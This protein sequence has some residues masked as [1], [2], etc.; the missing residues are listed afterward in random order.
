[1]EQ[2]KRLNH[3]RG[4][5]AQANIRPRN[6]HPDA[7]PPARELIC[8]LLIRVKIP[9]NQKL[10]KINHVQACS[11]RPSAFSAASRKPSPCVG[12]AWIVPAMSSSRA[13]ISMASE[14]AA[15]SSA[16][17]EPTA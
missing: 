12:W 13:P 16:T 11:G 4:T 10:K 7:N 6:F 14:K 15:E 17:P 1:M 8:I 9:R 5:F 3:Y 2:E